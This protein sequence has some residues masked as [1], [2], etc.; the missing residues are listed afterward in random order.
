MLL[1]SHSSFLLLAA[2]RSRVL[3]SA[4]DQ[5]GWP[6]HFGHCTSLEVRLRG[7]QRVWDVASIWLML[8]VL[9]STFGLL[10]SNESCPPFLFLVIQTSYLYP[11][12][13]HIPSLSASSLWFSFLLRLSSWLLRILTPLFQ[14]LCPGRSACPGPNGSWGFWKE[15]APKVAHPPCYAT[16]TSHL[17]FLQLA[18]SQFCPE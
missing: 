1:A 7:L 6:D 5:S 10:F 2:V 11:F 18:Q 13:S 12:F 3:S 15:R 9:Q 4:L 17:L 16:P 14:V 8:R